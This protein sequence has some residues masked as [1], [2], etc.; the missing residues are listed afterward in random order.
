M[1]IYRL[2]FSNI[3]V[4]FAKIDCVL[5]TDTGFSEFQRLYIQTTF[6][7]CHTINVEVYNKI[8]T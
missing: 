2:F 3:S 8:V 1:A 4:T 6:S 7:N 5:A